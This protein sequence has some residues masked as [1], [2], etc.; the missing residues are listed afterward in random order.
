VGTLP[1]LVSEMLLVGTP[2]HTSSHETG[3]S[4]PSTYCAGAARNIAGSQQ[5]QGRR[6]LQV[7][8]TAHW[9]PWLLDRGRDRSKH[10]RCARV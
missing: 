3:M 10:R 8:G 5:V 7:Y 1:S 6:L 9:V 4:E 2:L